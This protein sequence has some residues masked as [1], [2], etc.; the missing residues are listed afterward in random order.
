[1]PQLARILLVILVAIGLAYAFLAFRGEPE[2]PPVRTLPSGRTPSFHLFAAP[3]ERQRAVQQCLDQLTSG[4]AG[5]IGGMKDDIAL[6]CNEE[7][8]RR[9]VLNAWA[10]RTNISKYEASA[11]ADI[12]ALV[13][14]AD[15]VGPSKEIFQHP[16]FEVRSKGP[17]VARTQ[18]DPAFVPLL[19]KFYDEINRDHPNAGTQT[20]LIILDAALACGGPETPLILDRALKDSI[21]TVRADAIDYVARL[22]LKSFLPRL[23]ELLQDEELGVRVRAAHALGR[24]GRPAPDGFYAQGLD[25]RLMPELHAALEAMVDLRLSSYIPRLR[26][27]RGE[28]PPSLEGLVLSTLALLGDAEVLQHARE[29]LTS[30]APASTKRLLAL[31]VIA[32]AGNASDIE[33]VGALVAEHRPGDAEAVVSGLAARGGVPTDALFAALLDSTLSH[34]GQIAPVCSGNNSTMVPAVAQRLSATSDEARAAFLIG[35]LGAIDGSEARAA[36]L[37]AHKR[38][39]TLCEQQLRLLDLAARKEG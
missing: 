23:V 32:A 11:F 36:V 7:S 12:F 26:Q 24:L 2:A 38:F 4:A 15:F 30:G 16:D 25:A 27:F 28:V 33:R 9:A 14:S 20:R 6:L 5:L 35:V 22:Q 1:M 29:G 3:A 19:C 39:P 34:P 17:I 13:R 37:Q 10:G 8:T 18:R 21:A 31:Q